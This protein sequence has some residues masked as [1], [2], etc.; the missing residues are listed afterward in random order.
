MIVDDSHF[1]YLRLQRGAIEHLSGDRRAWLA[2]YERSLHD[3]FENMRPFLPERCSAVLDVGSGLGGIDVLLDR[4]YGGLQV[5]LFDGRADKPVLAQH[6]CTFNHMGVA[7]DFQRRNGVQLAV[8]WDPAMCS[9]LQA[10]RP[11]VDLVVSLASWCF[12]Y[13]PQVYLDLV[14]ALVRPAGTL[15]LDVRA[16]RHDWR[17]RLGDVFEQIDCAHRGRKFDRM[18]FRARAA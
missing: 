12:H 15:I 18:V 1:A 14:R 8:S 11:A 2:A 17:A 4:H 7:M 6:S 9:G 3:D 13:P 16:G 10:L 5:C